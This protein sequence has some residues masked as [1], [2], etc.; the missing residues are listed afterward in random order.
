MSNIHVKLTLFSPYLK[1]KKIIDPVYL[2]KHAKRAQDIIY[3]IIDEYV[4]DIL[5]HRPIELNAIETE[6]FVNSID[7]TIDI[8]GEIEDV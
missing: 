4:A 2:P 1:E 3:D 5:L 8:I 7:F 6:E